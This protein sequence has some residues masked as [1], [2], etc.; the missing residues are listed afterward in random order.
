MGE[1]VKNL[2]VPQVTLGGETCARCVYEQSKGASKE[3]CT[4]MPGD[5]IFWKAGR[6]EKQEDPVSLIT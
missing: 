5:V 1:G 6:G 2:S 4:V 3:V